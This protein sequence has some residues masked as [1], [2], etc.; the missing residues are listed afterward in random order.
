M[1]YAANLAFNQIFSKPF[2]RI[3][4]R[5]LGLTLLLLVLLWIAA[6]ALVA[7][8]LAAPYPWLDTAIAWATGAG[9]VVGLGFF[10]APVTS[11][12]AG[13]F[14]DEIAEEVERRFYPQD[15]PGTAM[16]FLKSLG[17]TARFVAVVLGVNLAA[18]ILVFFFGLG[19]PVF[20][21]ANGY[22][23]GREYF[24]LAAMRFLPPEDAK[25]LR[26]THFLKVF[27]AGLIVAGFLAIPVLNLFTPLFATAFMVH[28]YKRIVHGGTRPVPVIAG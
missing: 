25:A 1:L 16:P 26:R 15:P 18:L 11:I 28:V 4:W 27:I 14:L 8:F 12:F 13:I 7:T 21:V 24:E 3:L 5:S 20:F 6:Q 9:L 19:V 10:I 2:R 22:L 17:L 23:L